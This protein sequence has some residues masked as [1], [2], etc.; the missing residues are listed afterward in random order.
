MTALIPAEPFTAAGALALKRHVVSFR[1]RGYQWLAEVTR[2][3]SAG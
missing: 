2:R 3:V 1:E